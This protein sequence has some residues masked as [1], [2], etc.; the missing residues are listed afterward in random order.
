MHGPD[1]VFGIWPKEFLFKVKY[2]DDSNILFPEA[3]RNENSY[4]VIKFG[5][6]G[7]AKRIEWAFQSEWRYSFIVMPAPPP[8]I[9]KY[10]N[11][12]LDYG[13][14]YEALTQKAFEKRKVSVN[15]IFLK[16]NTDA[17]RTMEVMLGPKSTEEDNKRVFDIIKCINPNIPITL[18]SLTNQIR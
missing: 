7:H 6:I 14:S 18:S 2:T 16:V 15:E 3:Y 17:L 12:E 8:P 10:D 4:H 5:L 13:E 1:Y 11:Y 9:T